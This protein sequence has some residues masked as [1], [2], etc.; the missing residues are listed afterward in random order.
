MEKLSV[1]LQLI[2]LRVRHLPYFR[3]AARQQV[4]RPSGSTVFKTNRARHFAL[5]TFAQYEFAH[6]FSIADR[7]HNDLVPNHLTP[8]PEVFTM[9]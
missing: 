1:S 7:F 8:P 5:V 2:E 4:F 6:P 9:T 3:H